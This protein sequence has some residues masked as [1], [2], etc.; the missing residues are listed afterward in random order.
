MPANDS[1]SISERLSSE[2]EFPVVIPTKEA[3]EAEPARVSEE[4]DMLIDFSDAG[5][6]PITKSTNDSNVQ[7]NFSELDFLL[8]VMPQHNSV[9]NFP[10]DLLKNVLHEVQQEVKSQASRDATNQIP[11][12]NS[13]SD[14]AFNESSGSELK[15]EDTNTSVHLAS[16]SVGFTDSIPIDDSEFNQFMEQNN[17]DKVKTIP[18]ESS[19]W[20]SA[21]NQIGLHSP[22]HGQ[23]KSE[24]KGS[25]V[26]DSELLNTLCNSTE[27]SLY[28]TTASTSLLQ[29]NGLEP[30]SSDKSV[31]SVVEPENVDADSSTC[32]QPRFKKVF[33]KDL[34]SKLASS[35]SHK[36]DAKENVLVVE[37]DAESRTIQVNGLTN[38][39]QLSNS[40]SCS[41]ASNNS[42]SS[43]AE[44]GFPTARAVP[45]D[46]SPFNEQTGQVQSLPV[47]NQKVL[48][49]QIPTASPPSYSSVIAGD[50]HAGTIIQEGSS[51]AGTVVRKM[52]S[53]L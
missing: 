35:K 4:N 33:H 37:G 12:N 40:Q 25:A 10:Q 32:S 41:S 8:S 30:T 46:G 26:P 14:I 53:N 42:S 43:T 27:Q 5:Y 22:D 39:N 19:D 24:T 51:F 28:A 7:P 34:T 45:N 11:T 48:I 18:N 9:D 6:V 15:D 20:L 1:M 2:K 16:S 38:S 47:A 3:V 49:Q 17:L 52:C 31:K 13:N 44:A 50:Y 36:A 21:S 23:T 29:Q